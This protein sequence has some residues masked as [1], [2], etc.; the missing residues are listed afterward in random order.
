MDMLASNPETFAMDASQF[1]SPT[2]STFIPTL[3]S[4]QETSNSIVACAAYDIGSGATK[5][6]GALINVGNMTIEQIFSQGSFNVPYREDLHQSSNNQFSDLI[7]EMG[8]Q[9]L[10]QAHLQIEQ[11]YVG[12]NLSGYGEIQHF[13]VA[14]AAFRAADNGTFVA[15]NF[16]DKLEMPINIISQEE[17]GKLAYYSALSKIPNNDTLPIV[18]DIGGGSMQ[19]TFKDSSDT[20]HIM[21]GEMAS[22]TF[23]A[24]V[25]THI[26]GAED[27]SASPNPLNAA[28][29]DAAIELA[30]AHL[31]FDIT[32][33]EIIS[34]QIKQETPI[35]AV[36]TVHNMVISPLCHLAGIESN[37]DHYTKSD[38]RLAIELLTDKTDHDI[39]QLNHLPTLS[40]AKNQLTNLILVYAMMDLM[41]IEQV[42]TMKV[43]NVEGLM[44]MNATPPKLPIAS[45]I[46]ALDELDLIH[47]SSYRHFDIKC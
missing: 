38:L 42:Q 2:F 19:L 43:S 24:L 10:T 15:E 14:T 40:L 30:K 11:D 13:A 21:E 35:F 47:S 29:V 7:Q 37:A 32:S 33:T 16:S 20:F 1:L 41:G 6:M 9:A 36:G 26:K 18:W 22:Q 17:E 3:P 45:P 39:V 8:L 23:Q 28:N 25:T 12:Q 4:T 31:Q 34:N 46:F 44:V 5:Y 27:G